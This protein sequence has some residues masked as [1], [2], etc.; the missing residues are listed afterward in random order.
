MN[1][2]QTQVVATRVESLGPAGY[3]LICVSGELKLQ[4]L[5]TWTQG[6]D[7]GRE[8]RTLETQCVE[9]EL[10]LDEFIPF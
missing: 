8:W 5:F 6:R 9:T 10:T 1:S 7:F 4:G 2:Q 3:R